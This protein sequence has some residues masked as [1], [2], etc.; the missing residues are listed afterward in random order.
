MIAH[1]SPSI[2][3][4]FRAL[5][6]VVLASIGVAT[7][8][9]AQSSPTE[10]DKV[11]TQPNRD[12]LHLSPFEW[13]DSQNGNVMMHFPMLT[14]PGNAGRSLTFELT[15]NA[16]SL[17]GP[18]WNFGIAG[19][20]IAINNQAYP[21]GPIS[22]TIVDTRTIT[23]LLVMPDGSQKP[24]M[25]RDR[26]DSAD[27]TTIRWFVTS[28]LWK[29]DRDAA[30]L[31]L[32]DG[33]TCIYDAA[34]GRLYQVVDVDSNTVTLDWFSV[35]NQLTVVQ[36][37]GSSPSRTITFAINGW[38]LP[39]TMTYN[40][41]QWNYVYDENGGALQTISPPIGPGWTFTYSAVVDGGQRLTEVRTPQ[42]GTVTYTY[43]RVDLTPPAYRVLLDTRTV[44]DQNGV[45][46]TWRVQYQY[47]ESCECSPRT[48]VVTPS[49]TLVYEYGNVGVP[50]TSAL[51][52]GAWGLTRVTLQDGQ[53]TAVQ[54]ETVT[55]TELPSI[56][57]P[58]NFTFYAT[59]INQR[60]VARN[61]RTY[62]TTF[63][64]RSD[65]ASFDDY[66][67]VQTVAESGELTR[68]TTFTYQHPRVGSISDPVF[69]VGLQT[70]QQV[71]SDGE[72]WMR[73]WTYNQT[74][75][76]RTSA[77]D[78][79]QSSCAT[80]ITTTY[81][82]DAYGNTASETDGNGHTTSFTYKYGV[83]EDTN[84]PRYTI[85]RVIN[86]DGTVASVSE[87][88]RI[89][90]FTYDDVM[91]L[92]TTQPPGGTNPTT[93]TYDNA[94]GQT[95][96]RARGSS[97]VTTTF[98]GFGRTVRVQNSVGVTTRTSYDAEGHVTYEGYPFTG[99]SDVGVQVTYDVFDR[100]RTRTNPDGRAKTWQYGAGTHTITDE[101]QH[102]T[103]ETWSAFGD[104][105]SGRLASRQD[106]EQHTWTYG[107][108]GLG[109]VNQ[110]TAPD[111][112]I[113]LWQYNAQNR[114]AQETHPQ[115][116]QK[117]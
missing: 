37:L 71:D 24:T 35:P 102:Q 68:T 19:V 55:Y 113:R 27:A 4:F 117:N 10:F 23:P 78:F 38:Y 89:T 63:G 62:T 98:D 65:A 115:S 30:I 52:D 42:G 64:Y 16:N 116:G 109:Q 3:S 21:H 114:L 70:S 100:V 44:D 112:T 87:A 91:R 45:T 72:T 58:D 101:K 6:I 12:Y 51:I 5:I 14:L 96:T 106:G 59:A 85:H 77:T 61:G 33:T 86:S 99:Q 39:T 93:I 48:T 79:A 57:H 47:L 13:L 97:S 67:H 26:P 60:T 9:Q 49:R 50:H 8:A 46:G 25:F 81:G 88:D 83:L 17:V 110:V 54:T 76:F 111:V 40:G 80:A 104:P 41:H 69:V 36:S 94:N 22:D 43:Q 108:H 11:G 1:R 84:T 56:F 90:S 28:D 53:G 66:H 103:I 34:S 82:P 92:T 32:P 31:Y 15:Y 95:V 73:C 29:Y 75:G 74:T 18:V 105:D 107:Y 2:R 7:V 20:P